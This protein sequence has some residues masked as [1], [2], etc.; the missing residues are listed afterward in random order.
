MGSVLGFP[1]IDPQDAV[2]G[3]RIRRWRDRRGVAFLDLAAA[4]DLPLF[5]GATMSD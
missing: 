1:A 2:V 4:I 5:P 3:A